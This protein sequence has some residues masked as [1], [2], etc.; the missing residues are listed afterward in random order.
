M[1]RRLL[2][3]L[4][5][6]SANYFRSVFTLLINIYYF[7]LFKERCSLIPPS[8]LLSTPIDR[9]NG[10][11][12]MRILSICLCIGSHM[13][14]LMAQCV[15]STVSRDQLENP[16]RWFCWCRKILIYL[17]AAAI[18]NQLASTVVCRPIEI[19]YNLRYTSMLLVQMTGF[20]TC[21]LFA[22]FLGVKFASIE[23]IHRSSNI[24]HIHIH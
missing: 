8:L 19:L 17:V 11:K 22:F 1:K 18:C 13:F 16:Y 21:L 12:S 9:M 6:W 20:F 14:L 7:Y 24:N 10:Y 2:D 3:Y 5:S 23:P 15:Y 4:L